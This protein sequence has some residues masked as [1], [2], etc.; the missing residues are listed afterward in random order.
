MT[1]NAVERKNRNCKSDAK[2]MNQNFNN[3][4]F[5]YKVVC[6]K[7]ISAQEASNITYRSRKWKPELL[8]RKLDKSDSIVQFQK[9][10]LV[11]QTK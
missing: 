4:G 7:H 11:H 8:K 10:N 1:T 2:L 6:M 3:D 9:L 5:V